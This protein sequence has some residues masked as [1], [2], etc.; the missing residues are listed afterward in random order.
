MVGR[1][2]LQKVCHRCLQ[3]DHTRICSCFEVEILP[4]KLKALIRSYG[5]R[6]SPTYVFSPFEALI[7]RIVRSSFSLQKHSEAVKTNVKGGLFELAV[8]HFF[9]D[10][11]KS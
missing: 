8:L 11:S 1:P 7:L 10:L 3:V 6:V 9:V 4:L 2:G 5:C